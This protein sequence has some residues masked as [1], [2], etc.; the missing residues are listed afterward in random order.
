VNT[1]QVSDGICIGFIQPANMLKQNTPWENCCFFMSKNIKIFSVIAILLSGYSALSQNLSNK[2]KEF[3]V[4]YGHHQFFE[5]GGNT[6]EMVLYLSAEQAANVTVSINGTSYSQTYFVPANTVVSTGATPS[7]PLPKA[8]TNDCRLF[9]GTPG[10]TG[11][12]SE[13]KSTR[14]IHIVSDVP[15]VA[16][17]HIFGGTSSGAS[18]L[19]PIDTWGYNY[20]S[21]NSEQRYGSNCFSW[22]Y[23]IAKENNTKIEIVPSVPYPRWSGCRAIS[24]CSFKQGRGLPGFGFAFKRRKQQR[25]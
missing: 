10:F 21:V 11:T 5:T 17:A 20:V 25:I 22:M 14:G 9:S 15:I 24:Y 3:W 1:E 18:M 23:V 7:T 8:G 13:G 12:N 4:A 16:Y 19:M 6:Q 2:G